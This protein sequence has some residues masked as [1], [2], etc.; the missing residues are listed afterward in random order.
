MPL[1]W[2]ESGWI[3]A[4]NLEEESDALRSSARSGLEEE[5]D[6]LCFGGVLLDQE[7]EALSIVNSN[8][9]ALFR[10]RKAN[11]SVR[12]TKKKA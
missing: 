9:T 10:A 6:S 1:W 7:E 12:W 4:T 11:K 5:A 2:R 3:G 8:Q